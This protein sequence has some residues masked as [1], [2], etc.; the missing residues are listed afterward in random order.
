MKKF[1][2][3]FLVSF[4][5]VLCI[6]NHAVYADEEKKDTNEVQIIEE[7]DGTTVKIQDGNTVK[8]YEVVKLKEKGVD[9]NINGEDSLC[10]LLLA[11]PL[12]VF[13]FCAISYNLSLS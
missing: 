8:E 9:E 13:L 12:I 7:K 3:T 10:L 1:I 6:G 11:F 5:F 2:F 4:S